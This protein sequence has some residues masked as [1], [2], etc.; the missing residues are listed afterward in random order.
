MGC[1]EVKDKDIPELICQFEPNN[2][3]QK[4]YCLKL[5]DKLSTERKPAKTCK[6][7][8]CARAEIPFSIKLKIKEKENDIQTVF[9]DTDEDMNKALEEI[10]KFLGEQ[11]EQIQTNQENQQSPPTEQKEANNQ[12]A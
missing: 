12:Q 2:E 5:K 1:S 9:G 7:V 10:F 4:E 6:Y 11:K 3:K 8:I